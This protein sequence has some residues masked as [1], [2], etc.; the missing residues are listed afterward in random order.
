MKGRGEGQETA[1][2]KAGLK[3]ISGMKAERRALGG[4][5]V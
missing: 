5:K 1:S 4:D 2:Q 3:W